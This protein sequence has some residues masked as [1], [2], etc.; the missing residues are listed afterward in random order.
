MAQDDGEIG[1][2]G[3]L[4]EDAAPQ[5]AQGRGEIHVWGISKTGPLSIIGRSPKAHGSQKT[6]VEHGKPSLPRSTRLVIAIPPPALA[7]DLDH[8]RPRRLGLGQGDGE[9]AV[10]VASFGLAAIDG[11]RKHEGAAVRADAS[12]RS[13]V[14]LTLL[15]ALGFP[16]GVDGERVAFQLYLDVL[17]AVAGKVN[18]H[19]DFALGF[20]DVGGR[21]QRDL[22]AVP[23]REITKQIV[24]FGAQTQRRAKRED[25]GTT[26]ISIPTDNH[27][28]FLQCMRPVG[29]VFRETIPNALS[30]RVETPNFSL[31]Y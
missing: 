28:S 11:G 3:G 18:P 20:D 12:F 31:I 29:A 22:L 8:S 9:H 15:L 1:R 30:R 10:D 24:E 7:L 26:T 5:R 6:N 17:R 16:L 13:Q 23:A 21:I 14:V 2:S 19:L 4:L 27:V 25:F